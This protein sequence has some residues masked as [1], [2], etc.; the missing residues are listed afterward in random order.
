MSTVAPFSTVSTST[1]TSSSTP[2]ATLSSS[3]RPNTTPIAVPSRTNPGHNPLTTDE[4]VTNVLTT[5]VAKMLKQ[6]NIELAQESCLLTLSNVAARHIARVAQRAKSLAHASRRTE[7]NAIDIAQ[8][9]TDNRVDLRELGEFASTTRASSVLI[10]TFPVYSD[11]IIGDTP[12]ADSTLVALPS[13]STTLATLTG[14]APLAPTQSDA[15]KTLPHPAHVP[16]PL[17]AFPP[18][19]TYNITPVRFTPLLSLSSCHPNV[20]TPLFF[21][22]FFCPFLSLSPS[23][24]PSS[25]LSMYLFLLLLLY[26]PNF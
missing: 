8:S 3:S 5:A 16:P 23:P 14:G 22:L 6:S 21:T 9:L 13:A 24:P 2:L 25:C 11:V 20:P 12:R 4:Y 7:V 19:H 26:N 1:S 17:P 10:P 18:A 15:V